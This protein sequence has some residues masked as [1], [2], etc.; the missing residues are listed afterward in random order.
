MA[1]AQ[2][3]AANNHKKR[4]TDPGQIALD[5]EYG[6]L[7]QDLGGDFMHYH[8]DTIQHPEK[9]P[10]TLLHMDPDALR[11]VLLARIDELLEG[12]IAGATFPI[13]IIQSFTREELLTLAAESGIVFSG[14]T[15]NHPDGGVYLADNVRSTLRRTEPAEN[16]QLRAI[17]ATSI[18]RRIGFVPQKPSSGIPE[19]LQGLPR[20]PVNSLVAAF[21]ENGK[22]SQSAVLPDGNWAVPGFD[23]AGWQYAE[24][25]FEGMVAMRN[26]EETEEVEAAGMEME[27]YVDN[28]RITI[29]RPEE[30]ARRFNKSCVTM[31]LPPISVDQFVQSVLAAVKNNKKFIPKNGKLYIRPFMVGLRGATGIHPA[32]QALF[33]VEVSPFGKYL[34]AKSQSPEGNEKETQK[35]IKAKVVKYPRGKIGKDKASANYGPIMAEKDRWVQEGFS[36]VLMVD[37]E[38]F[39]EEFSSSN[40]VLVQNKGKKHFRI[41]TPSLEAD[42]LPGINRKSLTEVLRDPDIQRLL[43]YDIELVD[44]E[45]VHEGALDSSATTGV[46]SIG[47][48]AGITPYDEIEPR[49][50]NDNDRPKPIV[51][52]DRNG[53]L[54][55]GLKVN[56]DRI[57]GDLVRIK[58]ID[59]GEEY[60]VAIKAGKNGL[61]RLWELVKSDLSAAANDLGR[62]GNRGLLDNFANLESRILTTKLQVS[63]SRSPET[64]FDAINNLIVELLAAFRQSPSW[65]SST[66]VECEEVCKALVKAEEDYSTNINKQEALNA[67]ASNATETKEY[68][69]ENIPEYL[70]QIEDLLNSTIGI[71]DISIAT[72]QYL[73]ER[74]KYFRSFKEGYLETKTQFS[75]TRKFIEDLNT[76]LIKLR[77]G[78]VPGYEH[79]AMVVE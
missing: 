42:I 78:E 32:K 36:D 69:D 13:S 10:Q 59:A 9:F 4:P 56:L 6:K 64:H 5:K 62:S 11:D 68:H 74:R 70:K 7:E 47:T 27:L 60:K 71:K 46:F 57:L 48:A 14:I 22:W 67:L 61:E 33:A 52:A 34:A 49:S 3:G 55:E 24:G 40:M 38:G 29:F 72:M 51:Y 79:W 20:I 58:E 37:E 66:M 26:G 73:A 63:D 44:N 30:N 43:G 12:T 25:V 53:G 1:E 15:E 2:A 17:F 39:I 16:P 28:G 31:G 23:N 77:K 35:K 19:N 54:D 41:C 18:L 45:P 65:N 21:F 8:P 50:K 75:D 76:L